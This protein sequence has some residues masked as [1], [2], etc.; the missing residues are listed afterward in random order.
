[1]SADMDDFFREMGEHEYDPQSAESPLKAEDLP[2]GNYVGKLLS[3]TPRRVQS[4]NCWC[5]DWSVKITSGPEEKLAGRVFTYG[6]LLGSEQAKNRLGYELERLGV[7][8]KS[9]PEILQNAL[10]ILPG[11]LV[12]MRK[13]TSNAKNGKTYHNVSI[14]HL[15]EEELF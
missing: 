15:V 5:W 13:V 10:K 3:I 9:F 6:T 1:M 4:M 14:T 8:G 12:G 2:D 7:A 11:N